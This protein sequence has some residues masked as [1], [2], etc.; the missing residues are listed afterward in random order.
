MRGQHQ[1]A[2]Q[3]P[4]V[5]QVVMVVTSVNVSRAELTGSLAGASNA[6]WEQDWRD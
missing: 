1:A 3:V 2:D 4:A 6:I 5:K